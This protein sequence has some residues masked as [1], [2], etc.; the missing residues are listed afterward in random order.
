M[1]R[2]FSWGIKHWLRLA[3]VLLAGAHSLWSQSPA[4]QSFDVVITNGHI[5][6]GT[7]SPWKDRGDRESERCVPQTND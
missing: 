7:G 6:D 5:I 2:H 3:I 4:A 1:N